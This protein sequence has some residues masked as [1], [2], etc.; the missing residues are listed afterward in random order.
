MHSDVYRLLYAWFVKDVEARCF[1][2]E[3]SVGFDS[4]D[5]TLTCQTPLSLRFELRFAAFT[6]V[7]HNLLL[8]LLSFFTHCVLHFTCFNMPRFYGTLAANLQTPCY[9]SKQRLVDEGDALRVYSSTTL[10]S[11][12][13]SEHSSVQACGLRLVVG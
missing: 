13:Q 7:C 11:M 8:L 9:L 3:N 4:V 5:R 1:P 2:V 12:R 10:R 6:D